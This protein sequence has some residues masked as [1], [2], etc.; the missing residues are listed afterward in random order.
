M[1]APMGVEYVG[2]CEQVV[3]VCASSMVEDQE[4]LRVPGGGPLHVV[5]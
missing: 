1:Q 4:A 2:E 3:L 5:Q